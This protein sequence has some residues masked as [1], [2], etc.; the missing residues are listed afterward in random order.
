MSQKTFVIGVGMTKFD[1]PGSKE[2]DYSDW[3]YEAC[4]ARRRRE[5]RGET[6]KR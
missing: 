5:A 1:K 3:A 2:G 6:V 4:I